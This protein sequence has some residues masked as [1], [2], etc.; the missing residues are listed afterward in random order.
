MSALTSPKTALRKEFLARRQTLD[1]QERS[2]LS[3]QTAAHIVATA[4]FHEAQT[5]ATFVSMGSELDMTPST[6]AA[7]TAGKTV[8]VPR[9]GTGRQIGWSTVTSLTQLQP[10]GTHRPHEPLEALNLGTTGLTEADLILVPAFYIDEAGYRVGRGAAWYD[11]ALLARC[12]D[13]TL[14][15]IVYP[16]EHGDA[17]AF[18]HEPHDVHVTAVVTADGVTRLR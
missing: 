15:G 2:R 11:Q 12:T 14:F 10:A 3:A 9:L 18:D 1:S 7:L 8:L 4:E 6:T 13:A 16:W 5:V 17:F